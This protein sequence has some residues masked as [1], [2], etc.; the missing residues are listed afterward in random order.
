MAQL[1]L[2]IGHADPDAAV[3]GELYRKARASVADSVRYLIEAGQR[4]ARKKGELPHGSWRPWLEANA[5]AL[6]FDT[7][8]TAQRLIEVAI[9]YDASVAFTDQKAIEISR[10]IWGHN[11]RGTQ[12]TGENEWFT[13]PE[14]I[15]LA[16][17]VLGEI[18]LD[19]ATHET[20]QL[21][22]RATRYFTKADDGLAQEWH[23]RVW[24]N[25]PYAEEEIEDWV[26]KML[27]ERAAGRV[28]AAIML[29]HTYS[30]SA[31]FQSALAVTDAICFARK[32]V[33]F[34]KPRGKPANPTQ[35]QTF[36]YF[37]DETD[38]FLRAFRT[39]GSASL[40]NG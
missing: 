6:G 9:K 5:D 25:P 36:F 13:P 7:S 35:G 2:V 3:I 31:W 40:W 16:R 34:Y 19:P 30:S 26:M 14:H 32:R 38:K 23:G 24:L 33:K 8:R 28:T 21:M 37:G 29:T 15:Q 4:L 17:A 27:E 20:A 12:G 1:G 11:V 18:D 10:T 39:L 22:V